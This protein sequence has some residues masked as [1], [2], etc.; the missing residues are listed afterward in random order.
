[1][2]TKNINLIPDEKNERLM[3]SG[4]I[5][6][7]WKTPDEIKEEIW[8]QLRIKTAQEKIQQDPTSDQPQHHIRS[9]L[10]DLNVLRQQQCLRLAQHNDLKLMAAVANGQ[11]K[12]WVDRLYAIRDLLD[13][14]SNHPERIIS[15]FPHQS[16]QNERTHT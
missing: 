11:D 7:A 9:A 1:M 4:R 5:P 13:T 3:L 6:D 8:I 15:S 10:K 12:E 14:Y 2:Q 16:S